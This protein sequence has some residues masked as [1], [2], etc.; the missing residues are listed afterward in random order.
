MPIDYKRG[1]YLFASMFLDGVHSILLY[2]VLVDYSPYLIILH[3]VLSSNFLPSMTFSPCHLYS[4]RHTFS[5]WWRVK[6]IEGH[7][8]LYARHVNYS[9][10]VPVMIIQVMSKSNALIKY[11][12][13]RLK[14]H[15]ILMIICS[16]AISRYENNCNRWLKLAKQVRNNT[17]NS[18]KS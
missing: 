7:A 1:F 4:A 17:Y 5:W 16:N 2:G 8:L 11:S 6:S 9:C 18:I 13:I 14:L 3:L 15:S 12:S 10:V